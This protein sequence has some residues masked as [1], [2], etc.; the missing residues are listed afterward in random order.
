MASIGSCFLAGLGGAGTGCGMVAVDAILF[1]SVFFWESLQ[2]AKVEIIIF[3]LL[4]KKV[5]CVVLPS[6]FSPKT[7]GFFPF[8]SAKTPQEPSMATSSSSS[9]S[10][11]GP[12]IPPMGMSFK[13]GENKAWMPRPIGSGDKTELCRQLLYH[14]TCRFPDACR[15]AH[16]EEE[17][18]AKVK[19]PKWKTGPCIEFQSNNGHC[20]NPLQCSRYRHGELLGWI[21]TSRTVLVNLTRGVPRTM[22]VQ[23]PDEEPPAP[24]PS[25]PQPQQQRVPGRKWKEQLL[26]LPIYF[27]PS[28]GTQR[29]KTMKCERWFE[30]TPGRCIEGRACLNVHSDEEEF[31]SMDS[32]SD[33]GRI[34]VFE[35]NRLLYSMIENKET[36]DWR[37]DVVPPQLLEYLAKRPQDKKASPVSFLRD[38]FAKDFPPLVPAVGSQTQAPCPSPSP[39]IAPA[40]SPAIAPA[41]AQQQQS[42]PWVSDWFNPGPAAPSPPLAQLPPPHLAPAQLAPMPM[43]TPPPNYAPVRGAW[44][45]GRGGFG[46]RGGRGGDPYPITT[47]AKFSL[48]PIANKKKLLTPEQ[49]AQQQALVAKLLAT[50]SGDANATMVEEGP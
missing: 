23:Q 12:Q 31:N 33:M 37:L 22:L 34:F 45:G 40:A 15:S 6:F 36:K 3:F 44:R 28:T 4:L 19:H 35:S 7:S 16:K 30:T 17:V 21:S 32:S 2:F 48:Q 46:M 25:Q 42:Q 29:Y 43:P 8:V 41:P 39:A 1:F 26:R 20:S 14:G 47:S 38:T 9:S 24:A 49:I 5:L 50:S 27:M 11:D 13:G 18:C 10:L